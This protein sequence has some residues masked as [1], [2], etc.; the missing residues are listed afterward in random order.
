MM[1]GIDHDESTSADNTDV[2]LNANTAST[3][4]KVKHIYRDQLCSHDVVI[5]FH[6]YLER[7]QMKSQRLDFAIVI[8]HH[9]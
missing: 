8:R 3:L 9:K 4:P 5:V 1:H 6:V 2:F 7:L